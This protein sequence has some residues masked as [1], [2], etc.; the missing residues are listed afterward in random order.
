MAQGNTRSHRRRPSKQPHRRTPALELPE[1]VKLKSGC[2]ARIAYAAWVRN[3]KMLLWDSRVA[4]GRR[5]S[6]QGVHGLLYGTI[7]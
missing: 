7:E 3:I 5:Q 4:T 2:P 6:F 1:L